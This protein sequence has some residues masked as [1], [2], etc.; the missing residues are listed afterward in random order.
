MEKFTAGEYVVLKQ[1][2][3][4]GGYALLQVAHAVNV[5]VVALLNKDMMKPGSTKI[6]ASDA[7]YMKAY[8]QGMF[9]LCKF[10]HLLPTVHD[11]RFYTRFL[12]QQHPVFN[13]F[14]FATH[15][16]FAHA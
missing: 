16:T 10:V 13:R 6:V 5:H 1:T 11:I 3:D 4:E 12:L 9:C 15:L 2:T 7:G 8:R 14:F